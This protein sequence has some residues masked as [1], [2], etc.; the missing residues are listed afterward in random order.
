MVDRFW[1]PADEVL[2]CG[3]YITHKF[4]NELPVVTISVCRAGC[5]SAAAIVEHCEA[6]D[7]FQVTD[8]G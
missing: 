6:T 5:L 8:D 7:G 1:M 2:S 4:V 3:C